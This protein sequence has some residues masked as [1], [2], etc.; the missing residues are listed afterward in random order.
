MQRSRDTWRALVALGVLLVA[1]ATACTG[2]EPVPT[3]DVVARLE[4]FEI[5]LSSSRVHDGR[6]VI[7][8]QNDGPTVHEL[9]VART[10]RPADNLPIGA[11][12]LSVAEE[13]PRFRVLGEDE[14]VLLD[15][16]AALELTLAPGHYVL[17][18]NLPGHYLGGMHVDLEV[19]G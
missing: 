11:D 5:H 7:G 4:D 13:A 1:S 12:G 15:E 3:A 10:D 14:N 18:C 16:Q 19:E 9:V 8:M 2:D 17:F 6:V